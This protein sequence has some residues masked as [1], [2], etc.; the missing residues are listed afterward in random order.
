MYGI[1]VIGWIALAVGTYF[2]TK[3]LAEKD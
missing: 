3:G 1:D 2:I